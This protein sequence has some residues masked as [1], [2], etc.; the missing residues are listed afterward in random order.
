MS[1]PSEKCIVLKKLTNLEEHRL[2]MA[3][4][5]KEEIEVLA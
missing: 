4:K 1:S 5:E 2:K 3:L